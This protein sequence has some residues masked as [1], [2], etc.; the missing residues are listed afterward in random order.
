MML[1]RRRPYALTSLEFASRMDGTGQSISKRLEV[2]CEFLTPLPAEK[3]AFLKLAI[4]WRNRRV[5]SLANEALENT[6]EAVLRQSAEKLSGE[7]NGLDILRLL[8]QYKAAAPPSFKEAAS[9]IRLTQNAVAHFDAQLLSKLDIE[10][11]VR[12]AL[13]IKLSNSDSGALKR[14]CA[15]IW[16]SSEKKRTRV[17]RALRL[18]GIHQTSEITACQVPEPFVEAIV[19]MTPKLA[20]SYLT[21]RNVTAPRC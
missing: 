10:L 4:A 5:H 17:V 7:H 13:E 1:S 15:K 6:C 16:G 20:Y 11:Y 12:D 2:F 8:G 9:V 18:I 19:A 3:F 21:S 14:I